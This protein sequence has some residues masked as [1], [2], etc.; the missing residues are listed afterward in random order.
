MAVL[1]VSSDVFAQPRS[2]PDRFLA[3]FADGTI[4]APPIERFALDAA[5][6]AHTRLESRASIGALVLTT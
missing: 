3:H 2:S 6:Q 4:K 1:G 5:A